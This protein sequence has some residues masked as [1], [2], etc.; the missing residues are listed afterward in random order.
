MAQKKAFP[1]LYGIACTKYAFVA[2]HL[3]LSG[4]S[5]EFVSFARTAHDWEVD[6]FASFFRVLYSAR[7]RREGEDKL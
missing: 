6:V 5:I 2:A 1:Y 4:D 7:K 3:K